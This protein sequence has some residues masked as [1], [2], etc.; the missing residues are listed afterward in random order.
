LTYSTGT[1]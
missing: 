1:W